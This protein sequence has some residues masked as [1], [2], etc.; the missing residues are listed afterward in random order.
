MYTYIYSSEEAERSW[1]NSP[2]LSQLS[3]DD[4]EG[5]AAVKGAAAHQNLVEREGFEKQ[6]ANIVW[7]K[8]QMLS[9]KKSLTLLM[10]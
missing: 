6:F 1:A 9:L 10:L 3:E 4:R 8:P 7:K 5:P 2:P